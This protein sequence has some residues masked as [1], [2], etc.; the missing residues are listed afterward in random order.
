MMLL[1]F[2]SVESSANRFSTVMKKLSAEGSGRVKC[3][4][5]RGEV[6]MIQ[7]AA[8]VLLSRVLDQL[9]GAAKREMKKILIK[10][11]KS[12]A[13][14]MQMQMHFD[15]IKPNYRN[16]LCDHKFHLAA[17]KAISKAKQIY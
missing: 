1:G 6:F 9:L 11:V 2:A 4:K 17:S 7:W 12:L 5:F 8:R 3:A 10:E 14:Q 15:C 13:I 16:F